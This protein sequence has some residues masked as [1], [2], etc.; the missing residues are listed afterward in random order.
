MA[1]IEQNIE[2]WA[3]EAVRINIPNIKN[4]SSI[5]ILDKVEWKLLETPDAGDYLVLKSLTYPPQHPIT[6]DEEAMGI[7]IPLREND[8]L[9]IDGGRY[10]HEIRIWDPTGRPTTIMTGRVKI[11]HT[12]FTEEAGV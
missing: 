12:G 3:G 9:N 2:F 6:I 4:L 5:D 10:Y 7:S 1:E 11:N 8:T